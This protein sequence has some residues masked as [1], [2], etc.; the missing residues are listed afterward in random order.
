[1]H[2]P[3]DPR[4]A[5]ALVRSLDWALR[6]S[7]RWT[8]VDPD[9]NLR[10]AASGEAVL[11]VCRH[12]QLWPLLWSVRPAGIG[13]MVSRSSDGELLSRVLGSEHFRFLRGSSSRSGLLAARECI[14]EL[15]AGRSV[16]L[17]VDGPRGP[18]GVV[19]EGVLRI[20]QRG[21]VPVVP[22]R[23]EGGGRWVLQRTWD[24]FEVPLPGGR[25]EVHVGPQ[26]AVGS[27]EEGLA[28][29]RM[30]VQRILA[31]PDSRYGRRTPAGEL[32]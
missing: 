4:H 11:F 30:R 7:V 28:E 2:L 6:R 1:M 24:A 8:V 22:M 18:R 3:F 20:A 31:P 10:G 32:A 23:V 5:A 12:G 21:G 16:G 14:R 15:Q 25:L 13:V 9:D 19:Q 27:S 29:A 26:V 17:A